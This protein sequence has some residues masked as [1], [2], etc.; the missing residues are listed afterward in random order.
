MRVAVAGGVEPVAG[1]VLAVARRLQEPIDHLL[2][3]LGDVS[4]RKASTSAG[5]GGRPVRSSVTRRNQR[6]LAGLGGRRQALRLQPGEDETIDRVARPGGRL[7][8]GRGGRTGVMN[9]QCRPVLG[10][11]GDP[12]P[13]DLLFRAV[14]DLFVSAA[15]SLP[16]LR[17]RR[18]CGGGAS[19]SSG[20]PGTRT[21][22]LDRAICRQVEPDFA[23]SS[24][25]RGRDRR[26][27]CPRGSAGRPG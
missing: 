1:H 4:A 6:R 3:G 9:A 12:L 8:A 14:S 17:E 27:T 24:P 20:F 22:S 13:E 26:S 19:L 21:P 15:A 10:A 11:L 25:C 18:G 2:V 7:T 23:F 16:W 5:V